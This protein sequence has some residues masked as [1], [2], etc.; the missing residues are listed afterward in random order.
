[1]TPTVIC[2]LTSYGYRYLI[3]GG[4]RGYWSHRHRR[5]TSKGKA[6]RF[7]TLERAEL[8]AAEIAGHPAP[9]SE[10]GQ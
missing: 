6:S 2:R 9:E 1:M 10:V 5:W 8:I 7:Q 4:N 3:H